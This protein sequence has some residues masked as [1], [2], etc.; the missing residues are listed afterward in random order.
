VINPVITVFF[1][2]E[3]ALYT[4]T[5]ECVVLEVANTWFVEV[6]NGSIRQVIAAMS[7]RHLSEM[8]K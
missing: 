4:S 5:I 2:H 8:L 3:Q 6:V 1:R 7:T